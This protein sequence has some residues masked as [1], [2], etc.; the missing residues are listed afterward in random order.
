MMAK[1]ILEILDLNPKQ[2]DVGVEIEMESNSD[3]EFPNVPGWRLTHDGSLRGHSGEYVLTEPVPVK[4]LPVLIK[5]LQVALEANKME[6][7]YTFRAGVHVHVNVQQ[8]TVKQVRNFAALYLLLEELLIDTCGSDR[9]GN[10]F[11]LRAVD[12]EFLID[13]VAGVISQGR[14]YDLNTNDIRY[15]AI[16]FKALPQYGSIEFRALATQPDLEN[17]APWA[18]LLVSLREKA[19]TLENPQRILEDFSMLGS[20]GWVENMLGEY[21][22]MVK[23]NPKFDEHIWTGMRLAQDFIYFSEGR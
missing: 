5:N 14:L 15:A 23:D 19:K 4:D 18:N 3:N 20:R 22:Y 7:R 16:N 17:I 11:C 9:V 13:Y 1:R 6:I 12:A 21:Y 10:F 8:L 2:G